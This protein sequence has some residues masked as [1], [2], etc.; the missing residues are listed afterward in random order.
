MQDGVRQLEL[1]RSKIGMRPA[2]TSGASVFNEFESSCNLAENR[3]L[4]EIERWNVPVWDLD[5]LTAGTKIRDASSGDRM[6][7]GMR[8]FRFKSS[9]QLHTITK[10]VRS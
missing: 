8:Q 6:F 9:F 2:R 4:V 10:T 1:V 3:N 5:E 7:V